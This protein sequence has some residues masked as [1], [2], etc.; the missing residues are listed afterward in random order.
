MNEET[1]FRANIHFYSTRINV[2]ERHI[3]AKLVYLIRLTIFLRCEHS[4]KKRTKKKNSNKTDKSDC[5][6]EFNSFSS[7]NFVLLRWCWEEWIWLGNKWTQILRCGYKL[8]ELNWIKITF[9]YFAVPMTH[10]F[11]G[12]TFWMLDGWLEQQVHKSKLCR[13]QKK[14]GMHKKSHTHT[15][16]QSL[17]SKWHL[18][19]YSLSRSHNVNAQPK[20]YI[21]NLSCDFSCKTLKIGEVRSFW[22]GHDDGETM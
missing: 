20:P 2:N 15:H 4:T 21:R 14:R 17:S 5:C 16:A 9:T 19:T 7:K 12:Q 8:I 3:D 11:A 1:N 18:V 6:T 22:M 13:A 10:S